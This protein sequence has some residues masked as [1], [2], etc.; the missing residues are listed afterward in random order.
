[1]LECGKIRPNFGHFAGKRGLPDVA[2][3]D[4]DL[5]ETMPKKL[6]AHTGMDAMT[7]AIEAYVSTAHC[8]YTDPLAIFAIRMMCAT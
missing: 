7:H 6:V 1:M 4:P 8:D 2:I 3:V 5:A